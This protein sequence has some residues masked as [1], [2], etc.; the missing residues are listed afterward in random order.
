MG[1]TSY[2]AR[3]DDKVCLLYGGKTVYVVREKRNRQ[4]RFICEAYVRD[5]MQAQGMAEGFGEEV[6]FE[7][8]QFDP[9]HM[10]W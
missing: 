5:L 6:E 2:S 7:I 3:P 4:Y 8:S 9:L 1:L 10:L